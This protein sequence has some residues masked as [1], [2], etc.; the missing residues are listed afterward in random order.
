M[1]VHVWTRHSADCKHAGKREFKQCRC[2]KWLYWHLDSKMYRESAKTRS[3]EKAEEKARQKEQDHELAAKGKAPEPNEAVTIDKAVALFLADKKS[4]GLKPVT[5]KKLETMFQ[6][7]MVAWC[8][9][10]GV[11]F[12]TEFTLPRLQA[13]RG[14]WADAP[15]AAKKKQERIRGFFAFAQANGWISSNPAKGLSRIKVDQKPTDYFT[16]PEYKALIDATY[17][18]DQQSVNGIEHQNNQTRLRTLVELMRWSG[19]AI[20]DAV[21]LERSRLQDDDNLLM[22]RAKTGEPVFLPL[23]KHLADG[24]R[25]IPPGPKP[26]P[27]YFFWSG[28]GEPKSCVADWQRA[29]RKLTKIADLKHADGSKKRAH[30]HMLRDTFAVEALLAGVPMDQV[31]L[32]L[33]HSSIKTTERSYAPFVK[34]RREQLVN[35]MRNAWAAMA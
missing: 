32:L 19:L 29:F 28:N 13:W 25:N 1:V 5:L 7:Q 15:L 6:K 35:T 11:L 4:Q 26:N 3:W 10:H 33:G 17:A 12:L 21:T 27:R 18:Y 24:L 22:Y 8:R 14:S 20:R 23:P 31:S 34:A 2:P 9:D 30:P 16:K